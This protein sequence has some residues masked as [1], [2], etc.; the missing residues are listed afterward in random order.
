MD[1]FVG[2]YSMKIG[3][4]TIDTPPNVQS[5]ILD[6]DAGYGR[7]MTFELPIHKLEQSGGVYYGDYAR[8]NRE[9]LDSGGKL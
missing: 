5:F 1:V 7:P 9:I 3:N 4:L 8:L 2:T 6:Y